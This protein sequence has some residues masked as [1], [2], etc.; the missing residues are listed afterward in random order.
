M[1]GIKKNCKNYQKALISFNKMVINESRNEEL[2]DTET[3]DNTNISSEDFSLDNNIDL[4][5]ENAIKY[6]I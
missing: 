4:F 5:F 2:D 6:I 1:S 3:T